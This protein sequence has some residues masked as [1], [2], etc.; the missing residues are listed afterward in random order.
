VLRANGP[1]SSQHR[2]TPHVNGQPKHKG[3]RPAPSFAIQRAA[4]VFELVSLR[5]M[6]RAFSPELVMASVSWGVAPGWDGG[7]PLALGRGSVIEAKGPRSSQ[8]RATS[9]ANGPSSSQHRATPDVL[10]QPKYKGQ[11]PAPSF[12]IQR[13]ARVFELNSLCG[14]GRAFSPQLVMAGVLGRCPR[15]LGWRRAVGAGG[16]CG[17][18]ARHHPS[19]G[20]RPMD[21]ANQIHG[22]GQSK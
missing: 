1:S 11:R 8:H 14:M 20:Q 22:F 9:R 2:A 4:R 17:P 5:G 18:K 16:N 12:A 19:M 10:V 15:T 6:V 7:A 13:A 21:L 3:Q